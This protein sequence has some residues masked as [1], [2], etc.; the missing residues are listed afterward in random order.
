MGEC[1]RQRDFQQALRPA[2]LLDVLAER[3]VDAVKRLR[4]H[5]QDVASRLGQHELLRPT[6]EQRHAEE[7]FQHHHMPADRAL[8]D[9][10]AIGGGSET[11][12]LTRR[13][14]RAQC[15]Q[16]Q[17]FAIHRPSSPRAMR[18][19]RRRARSRAVVR[20]DDMARASRSQ[21]PVCH[22]ARL[23]HIG[24]ARRRA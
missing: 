21:G 2:L 10:E 19:A 11:Q 9:G 20:C 7:V 24:T 23:V 8:G 6:L 17:P 16:R 15:V 18:D 1:G 12:V 5:R 13:F 14:E 3:L 22:C 4:H